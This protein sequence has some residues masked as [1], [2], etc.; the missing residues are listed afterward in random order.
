[1]TALSSSQRQQVNKLWQQFRRQNPKR[2]RDG[3]MFIRILEHV[4]STEPG[5]IPTRKFVKKWKQNYREL[6]TQANH[7]ENRSLDN[8]RYVFEQAACSRC[9]S[10][11]G[12]GAKYGPDLTAVSKRFQGSKLLLQLVNPSQEIHKDF[13]TQM[14]LVDDG[15]LLTGL[16]VNETPDHVEIVQNLLRP[17]NIERIQKSAIEERKVADVSSMPSGLLDTFTAEDILDLLAFV[18]SS[19]AIPAT[20]Q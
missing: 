8:G 6:I 10:I 20:N 17:E 5:A 16:V 18:E 9:H 13:K 12:K 19:K 4:G 1:M 7:L 14:I 11:E 15:R 3:Q 2:S